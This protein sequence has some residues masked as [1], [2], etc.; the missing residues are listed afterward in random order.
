MIAMKGKDGEL[1]EAVAPLHLVSKITRASCSGEPK[2]FSTI[3]YAHEHMYIWKGRV[4][5][6][7]EGSFPE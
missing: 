5:E 1:S 6:F 2:A 4:S 3:M 7:N